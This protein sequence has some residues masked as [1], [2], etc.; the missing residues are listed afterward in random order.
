MQSDLD[1]ELA[2]SEIVSLNLA[3]L[4]VEELE[5]RLEMATAWVGF[6]TCGSNCTGDCGTNCCAALS[7]NDYACCDQN[8]CPSYGCE[9][10]FCCGCYENHPCDSFNPKHPYMMEAI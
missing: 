9:P 4:D 8:C 7:C 3:D 1:N 5:R 6:D 2:L 10:Y